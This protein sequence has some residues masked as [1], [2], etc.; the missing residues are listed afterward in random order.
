LLL[1]A[2]K[3]P[4]DLPDSLPDHLL[5]LF[6]QHQRL[7]QAPLRLSQLR[8]TNVPIRV[9]LF[10]N[11]VGRALLFHILFPIMIRFGPQMRCKQVE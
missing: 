6:Q 9:A 7:D 2:E 10:Q 11:M 5:G 3:D 4:Q 1:F 8:R